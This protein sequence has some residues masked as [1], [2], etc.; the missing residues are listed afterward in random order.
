MTP[1]PARPRPIADDESAAFWEAAAA[2]VLALARCARCARLVHPPV[3][4]CPAC[5]STEPNWSFEPVDG[6]GVVRSWTVL[7][8]AFL[9]GF[10]YDLPVV[11]VDV[12]LDVGTA[13]DLRLIGRLLDGPDAPLRRGAAVTVAFEELGDGAAVP[14]FRLASR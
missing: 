9:P 8:Q 7:R 3:P 6:R 11:L 14:A 13:S 10:A 2:G 5:G 12:A 4:V 1:T